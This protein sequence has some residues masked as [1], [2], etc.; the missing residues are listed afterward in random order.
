MS[1]PDRYLPFPRL[2]P[3]CCPHTCFRPLAHRLLQ[4]LDY[5]SFDLV[6]QWFGDT[7]QGTPELPDVAR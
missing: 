7:M 3:G 5:R 6:L 4:P 1:R 2:N